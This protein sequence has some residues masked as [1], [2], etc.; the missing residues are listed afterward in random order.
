MAGKRRKGDA[1]VKRAREH[2]DGYEA[3]EE[4]MATERRY[5]GISRGGETSLAYLLF[6]FFIFALRS[7]SFQM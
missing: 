4:L 7:A 5:P 1:F 6:R 2:I 3:R